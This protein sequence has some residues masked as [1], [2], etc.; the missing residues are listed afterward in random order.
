MAIQ[1]LPVFTNLKY[2]DEDGYL[3]PEAH[4]YSDQLWQTLNQIAT[5]INELAT[6]S[7]T[8]NSVNYLGLVAPSYTT[9][10][11]VALEVD[12][13]VGTIW[14]N[15]TLSKLQLKTAAGVIETI[16]ST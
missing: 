5:L 15:T 6:T 3:T 2:T 8:S 4:L 13:P 16:T 12:A 1:N 11:I 10:E 14:F 9:A 7:V